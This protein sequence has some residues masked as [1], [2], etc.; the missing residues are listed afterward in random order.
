ML[1]TP[2]AS[3]HFCSKPFAKSVE[4]ETVSSTD[5]LA[6]SRAL[7]LAAESLMQLHS[8]GRGAMAHSSQQRRTSS[9]VSA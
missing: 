8:K 1:E 7:A 5:L 3:K 6:A 2:R 9:S 4:S